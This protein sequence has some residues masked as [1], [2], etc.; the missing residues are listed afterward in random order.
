MPPILCRFT[1]SILAHQHTPLVDRKQDIMIINRRIGEYNN[2]FPP[3]RFNISIAPARLHT[4]G[5]KFTKNK[6]IGRPRSQMD[7]AIG[8]KY[9]QW[10]EDSFSEQLHLGD[11]KMW[12]MGRTILTYFKEL[13]GVCNFQR[14]Q[15]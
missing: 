10:R 8:H 12:K 9:H 13:Y 2:S 3:S 5:V 1:T 6:E 14:H 7:L 15:E 4:Y 11:V